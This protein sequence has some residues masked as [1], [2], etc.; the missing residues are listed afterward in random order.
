MRGSQAN[1]H[2]NRQEG[3][4]E[5]QTNRLGDKEESNKKEKTNTGNW[6]T[7]N[8]ADKTRR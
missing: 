1:K 2:A 4:R 8:R 6:K 7:S 3:K 5:R